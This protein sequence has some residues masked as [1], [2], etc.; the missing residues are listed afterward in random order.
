MTAPDWSILVEPVI[1]SEHGTEPQGRFGQKKRFGGYALLGDKVFFNKKL[2]KR[3]ALIPKAETFISD[4]TQ[5]C[6]VE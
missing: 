2:S 1:W 4:W 3:S 5:L 6:I